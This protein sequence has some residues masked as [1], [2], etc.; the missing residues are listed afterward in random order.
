MAIDSHIQIP[1]SILKKFSIPENEFKNNLRIKHNYVYSIDMS[2]QIIKKDIKDC[3]VMF[4][5]FDDEVEQKI[6]KKYEDSIGEIKKKIFAFTKAK[7]IQLTPADNERVKEFLVTTLLRSPEMVKNYCNHSFTWFLFSNP[8]Q[9][10][11][12]YEYENYKKELNKMF[13][14]YQLNIFV[15]K[16]KVNFIIPQLCF[17]DVRWSNKQTMYVFP[18]STNIA[19]TLNQ[20]I[21]DYIAEDGVLEYQTTMDKAVIHK[22][23]KSAIATEYNIN[24]Q[25]IYAKE[26]YDLKQYLPYLKEI[27]QGENL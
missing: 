11:L 3:N 13:Q 25:N 6:I 16:T 5:Y 15:N 7:T 17:Y 19:I 18:I 10:H 27:S 1:K 4:G 21:E 9:N 20:N 2:G 26:E 14:D 23:N 24:K 22:F 8:P 12:L